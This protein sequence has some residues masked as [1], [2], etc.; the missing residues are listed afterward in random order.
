MTRRHVLAIVAALILIVLG[1]FVI[2]RTAWEQITVPLPLAGEARVNPFY[3]AQRFSEALG[4][5]TAWIRSDFVLPPTDGV[6][7]LSGWHWDLSRDRRE[8]VKQWV[9]A[10]GRLVVDHRLASSNGD[11]EAWSGISKQ[12]PDGHSEPDRSGEECENFDE[13]VPGAASGE[14]YTLC[15]F[16]IWSRLEA[17]ERTPQWAVL[18]KAGRQAIRMSVRSGSVTFIN[19]APFRYRELLDGDHARLFVAATQLAAGDRVH[20]A[21]EDDE[22][23]LLALLWRW[24]AAFVTLAL[25]LV[26]VLIWRGAVRLGPVMPSPEAARRSLAEQIRGAARF[27]LRHGNA[28][29]LHTAA[30]RALNEAGRGRIPAF[31]GLSPVGQVEALARVAGLDEAALSNAFA[32]ARRG[33]ELHAHLALLETARRAILNRDRGRTD[34]A[35]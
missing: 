7:V 22:S 15:G 32:P 12:F 25:A 3:G 27:D 31:A 8:S 24:G 21:A 10:G 6:L 20:F 11:F 4:A 18:N 30:V 29:A 19:A 2:R 17:R 9:E 28:E 5:R 35:E 23:S 14:H 26:A 13:E 34:A 16:P 1:A 33:P